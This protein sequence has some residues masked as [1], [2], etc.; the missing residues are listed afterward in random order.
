[1]KYLL[2]ILTITL[3]Y[4]CGK[5]PEYY[6]A[7]P[8]LTSSELTITQALDPTNF[9]N[10]V[11]VRAKVLS[12]CKSEGCWSVLSD[13]KNTLRIVFKNN[14]FASPMDSEGKT[15]IVEG[16]VHSTIVSE[17]DARAYAINAGSL[18]DKANN[19]NGE[20]RIPIMTAESLR[21]E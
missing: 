12:V 15:A 4:S 14:S 1:M 20:Q 10:P 8:H 11:I 2:Y 16:S 6:G 21:F 19:I 5:T 7:K 17:S 13:N 18:E 9:N 3:L